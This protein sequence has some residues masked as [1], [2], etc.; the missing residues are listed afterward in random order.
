MNV[1]FQKRG[2]G[3]VS[4]TQTLRK[5][6]IYPSLLPPEVKMCRVTG[7]GPLS[8]S[9]TSATSSASPKNTPLTYFSVFLFFF[10]NSSLRCGTM[11]LVCHIA[12]QK[13]LK[14]PFFV[15]KTAAF[16][17]RSVA[18]NGGNTQAE[19]KND[20]E[21]ASPSNGSETQ[22]KKVPWYDLYVF[23]DEAKSYYISSIN[24]VECY[25]CTWIRRLYS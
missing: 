20:Q 4:G 25:A 12:S 3:R 17:Q 6:S 2:L 5:A 19:R 9:Q 22:N 16:L 8:V 24:C 21:N 13:L 18:A 11:G 23:I 7:M 15:K 10:L 14:I 1:V